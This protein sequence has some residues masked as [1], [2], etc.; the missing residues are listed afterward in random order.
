M[1]MHDAQSEPRA[2]A[3]LITWLH[4]QIAQLKT[5]IGRM[6]QQNDQAQAAIVDI[7]EAVRDG[8]GKLREMAAKTMGL[9]TMQD[10]LRQVSGL[11][12]RIQDAEVLID[13]KFEVLERQSSEERGRDQGEKNDLYK[14][15]QDLERRTE[16]LG[17]RQ[18]SVDEG[19]RRYQEEVSRTHIQL[20]SLNQRLE[21]VESKSAR[22]LESLVRLDQV[23][24]E[25]EAAIRA[26]RREDDVIA[27]RLRLAQEVGARLETELHAQQEEYRALP[28]LSERVELLRA[29]RQRLEDRTSHVEESLEDARLRLERQEESTQHIDVRL[30]TMEAR[31]DH[32]HTT[33]L[34]YRRTLTEQILK[35]NV[36]IERMKRRRMEELDRD[37]K[38]LRAQSNYLKNTDE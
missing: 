8:E 20:Q 26:L 28:L 9:P 10:Q 30:K 11:L 18:T 15:V 17:E 19:N 38:E 35:L 7:N 24:G 36:M 5:Q 25:T 21:A 31:L 12:D 16:G 23:Q 13:T 14:R 6:Q 33:T 1:T 2:S 32:V 34:D 4:D 29:E 22:S 27:E 3:D 37:V